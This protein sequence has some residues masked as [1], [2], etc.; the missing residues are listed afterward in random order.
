MGQILSTLIFHGRPST[1]SRDAKNL[2]EMLTPRANSRVYT[3]TLHLPSSLAPHRLN[4]YPSAKRLCLI[5]HPPPWAPHPPQIPAAWM[6]PQT[7]GFPFT[8]FMEVPAGVTERIVFL[9]WQREEDG[10]N[11]AVLPVSIGGPEDLRLVAVRD[12]EVCVDGEATV[13]VAV[14]EVLEEAIAAVVEGVRAVLRE[15][16]LPE[17]PVTAGPVAGGLM[18]GNEISENPPKNDGAGIGATESTSSSHKDPTKAGSPPTAPDIPVNSTATSIHPRIQGLTF[19]DNLDEY[20]ILCALSTFDIKGVRI[21]TLLIDDGWQSLSSGPTITDVNTGHSAKSRQLLQ[22]EACPSFPEGIASTI[23]EIRSKYPYIREIILWHSLFGCWGGIH[24]DSP[25]LNDYETVEAT[26]IPGCPWGKKRR[27]ICAKDVGRF[28]DDYYRFLKCAGADGI[29]I[30]QLIGIMQFQS[31]SNGESIHALQHAYF[32]AAAVAG[33]KYFNGRV[34][35]S[36]GHSPLI[37]S[38]LLPYLTPENVIRNSYDYYPARTTSHLW[39]VFMNFSN[40]VL[41]THWDARLDFD[42]YQ[43]TRPHAS[44]QALARCLSGTGLAISDTPGDFNFQMEGIVASTPDGRSV[45]LSLPGKSRPKDPYHRFEEQRLYNVVNGEV[46]AVMNLTAESITEAVELQPREVVVSHLGGRIFQPTE[47][48]VVVAEVTLESGEW[49]IFTALSWVPLGTHSHVKLAAVG[50]VDIMLGIAAVVD[51]VVSQ[52]QAEVYVHLCAVGTLGICFLDPNELG[53][54]HCLLEDK[55]IPSSAV[56]WSSK[57]PRMLLVDI[58][59]VWTPGEV[60][61]L[62]V[63]VRHI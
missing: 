30:D 12:G 38:T 28:Y 55:M 24:S 52:E 41:T 53:S 19:G 26:L 23:S 7:S 9:C 36:M 57:D 6:Y 3:T 18:H 22:F 42:M 60:Q 16:D 21:S 29:K 48:A 15:K 58:G 17:M 5:N 54:I 39:H 56:N 32:S 37:T 31:L 43:S 51:V 11:V 25:L 10:R 59:S 34:I 62:K 2:H 1:P 35:Y 50:L 14:G 49:E 63:T 47:K 27:V 46:L 13:V 8:E 45:S 61:T 33:R 44:L 4:L 20:S 40:S